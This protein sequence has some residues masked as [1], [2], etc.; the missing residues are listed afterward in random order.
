MLTNHLRGQTLTNHLVRGGG[1]VF[2]E[3]SWD[4]LGPPDSGHIL[5]RVKS[6]S[7]TGEQERHRWGSRRGTARGHR[8]GRASIRC[9]DQ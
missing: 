2:V 9:P 4:M 7:R 1:C 5:G 8:T 3:C 6:D